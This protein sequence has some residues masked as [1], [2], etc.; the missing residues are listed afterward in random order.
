M[1]VGRL[2]GKEAELM[3]KQMEE[4]QPL[5]K[6]MRPERKERDE[7]KAE[8]NCL[9]TR[10]GKGLFQLISSGEKVIHPPTVEALLGLQVCRQKSKQTS[11]IG[12]NHLDIYTNV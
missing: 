11:E 9:K 10:A 2:E 12:V 5:K 7:E 8:N 4:K 6:P 3:G 1:E